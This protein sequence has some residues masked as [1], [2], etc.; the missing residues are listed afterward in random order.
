MQTQNFGQLIKNFA[1][2]CFLFYFTESDLPSRASTRR[3][4]RVEKKQKKLYRLFLVR[5]SWTGRS[6]SL[7]NANIWQVLCYGIGFTMIS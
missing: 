5:S 4:I 3:S 1:S 6:S 2:F 7:L